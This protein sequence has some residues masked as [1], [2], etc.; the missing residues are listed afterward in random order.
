M[1]SSLF[2]DTDIILDVV[3]GREEHYEQSQA[4]FRLFEN[5]AAILYTTPSV[6]INT[7]YIAERQLS[8][9]DAKNAMSYLLQYFELIDASKSAIQQAYQSNFTNVEDAI[10]FFTVVES[11]VIDCIITRNV[12][13][14][15]KNNLHFPI[16]TPSQFLKLLK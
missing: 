10:Q 5:N 1:S 15:K 8:K 14:Y 16:Y 3:L 6:I 9:P 12:K 11:K 4:I 7:Q 13:D 2:I